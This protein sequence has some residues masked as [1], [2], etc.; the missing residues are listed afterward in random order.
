MSQYSYLVVNSELVDLTY[1]TDPPEEFIH[2][3]VRA[4]EGGHFVYCNKERIPLAEFLSRLAI[5]EEGLR[6]AG[7]RNQTGKKVQSTISFSKWD[8]VHMT[9]ALQNVLEKIR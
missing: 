4:L 6:V 3:R 7:Y 1:R 2:P 8:R 9:P 5:G